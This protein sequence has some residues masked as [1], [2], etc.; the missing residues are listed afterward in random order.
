MKTRVLA[1]RDNGVHRLRVIA[2]IEDDEVVCFGAYA[3]VQ[4]T[5]G[6]WVRKD[7]SWRE[8]YARAIAEVYSGQAVK[9]TKGA[10]IEDAERTPERGNGG[11][12][13]QG[14]L[15]ARSGKRRGKVAGNGG[16]T[17]AG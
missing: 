3:E 2:E 8:G 16:R 10:N 7:S 5:D 6:T 17:R 12:A 4:R 14:L 9:L 1:V 15:R 13:G 11:K